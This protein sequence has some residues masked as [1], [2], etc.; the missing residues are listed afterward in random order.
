MQTDLTQLTFDKLFEYA[1][2]KHA[3]NKLSYKVS[4]TSYY[5]YEDFYH[6]V[7]QMSQILLERGITKG[8]KV[9]L[10]SE[11]S[12]H[13]SMAYFAI[14]TIGAVVVPILT[15]FHHNEVKHILAS[16]DAKGL[17]VSEK[18]NYILDNDFA[19]LEFAINLDTLTLLDIKK[20]QKLD[21]LEQFRQKFSA[22]EATPSPTTIKESDLAAIIYTSGTTGQSKGV[23]LTHKNLVSQVVIADHTFKVL[24]SDRSISLLPMAH[25]FEMSI[26]FL[27]P[28]YNGAS[29]AYISKAPTPSV[30][31]KSF[32]E[33]KPTFMLVVPLIIEKI[34][35]NKIYPN[36]E[37]NGVIKF[38]YRLPFFKKQLHRIAGKKMMQNFGGA[39]RFLGI[40]GSKLSTQVEQ[41][42][43][44]AKFPYAI[45]YGLTETSP[46]SIAAVNENVK[47]GSCGYNLYSVSARLDESMSSNEGEGELQI[48]GPNV[49]QGYYKDEVRTKEAFSEDGW[50]RTGDL[51]RIDDD[52]RIYITGRSKNVIIGASGENIYPEAIES[53][54][55]AHPYVLES[56]IF[57]SEG[58]VTARIYL[59]YEK[60]DEEYKN[61]SSESQMQ[62]I[63][64]N[65]LEEIRLYTNEN[66]A[67]YAR[68]L[69]VI[70]QRE[71]FIMTPTK[72]IKR[73]LYQ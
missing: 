1:C 57:E 10:L 72:K 7:K 39:V 63:V 19:S 71:E 68:V 23:M 6:S 5:T 33:V 16:S 49:M 66:I 13:W 48:L 65:I 15:D 24:P 44:D 34:F 32:A 21:F 2:D 60:I 35:K 28:F 26:N 18:Q 31:L 45:G 29:I 20:E 51:A 54:M 53:I 3:Q 58:K 52:G 42:L 4:E 70:E 9:A 41:F 38:L 11:N 47:V 43:Y 56:L 30:L 25:T 61:Q 14:T 62:E 46:L 50:Y 36:F 37:K 73:F 12:P 22:Q 64:Q 67:S 40:G 69:K 55:N 27:V 17:F 59:N 8:D